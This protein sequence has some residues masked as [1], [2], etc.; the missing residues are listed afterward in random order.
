MARS[1]DTT[2]RS[3]WSSSSPVL[4]VLLS[5]YSSTKTRESTI[6]STSTAALICPPPPQIF[7]APTSVRRVVVFLRL[8][9]LATPNPGTD[10]PKA[11]KWPKSGDPKPRTV[12][13]RAQ[14]VQ[15]CP[16]V[17]DCAKTVPKSRPISDPGDGQKVNQG[18]SGRTEFYVTRFFQVC[19]SF[20]V[21]DSTSPQS[22]TSG[23]IK[24]GTASPRSTNR[25]EVFN[26]E[27]KQ[28]DQGKNS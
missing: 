5:V 7:I 12:P 9:K 18:R 22:G 2:T 8:R 15:P 26:N 13:N 14:T 27:V 3:T 6:F 16:P 24:A 25:Q 20:Y 23:A 19:C 11:G 17:L 10:P 21:T 4:P 28:Y 1:L